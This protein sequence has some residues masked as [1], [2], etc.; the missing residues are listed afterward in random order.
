MNWTQSF[1]NLL[2]EKI[3]YQ[4]QF[5]ELCLTCLRRNRREWCWTQERSSKNNPQSSRSSAVSEILSCLK[6]QDE[7][8]TSITCNICICL[9]SH[10]DIELLC[11]L[12]SWSCSRPLD[13]RP[14][15]TCSWRRRH[16]HVPRPPPLSEWGR[17][18]SNTD[19]WTPSWTYVRRGIRFEE[20][21]YTRPRK[22]YL[23]ISI[24]YRMC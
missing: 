21:H 23:K 15:H 5:K 20:G 18:E 6:W 4:L 24:C 10:P 2:H 3:N 16:S 19:I 22:V 17:F 9:F 12:C 1:Y 14:N 8:I 11:S 13:K 7:L